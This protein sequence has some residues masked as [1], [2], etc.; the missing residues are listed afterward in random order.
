MQKCVA[1]RFYDRNDVKT[2]ENGVRWGKCRR[3]GPL[4]HPLS[5]KTYLVEGVWPSVRDDDWCGE[6]VLGN[7][8]P[9]ATAIA[10]MSSL[11]QSAQATAPRAPSAIPAAPLAAFTASDTSAETPA[12]PVRPAVSTLMRGT[13]QPACPRPPPGAR[14]GPRA[15]DACAG[16]IC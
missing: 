1:C 14:T 13:L 8:Q 6:W 10:A 5:A 4:L 3:T 9:N 15:G 11:M 16:A 7:R 12:E 2:E